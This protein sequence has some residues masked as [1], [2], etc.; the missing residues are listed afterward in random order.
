MKEKINAYLEEI[1]S[2][3]A[4]SLEQVEEF[5]IKFLSKK[6]IV[7]G[8]FSE[9]KN[10]PPELRKEMGKSGRRLIEENYSDEIVSKQLLD[11][12]ECLLQSK[13]NL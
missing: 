7:P 13:I 2:F 8:L 1:N 6:G 5:R 11:I 4:S 9:M 3:K 12:Y 10:I